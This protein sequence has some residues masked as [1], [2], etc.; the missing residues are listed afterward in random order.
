MIHCIFLAIFLPISSPCG[1]CLLMLVCAKVELNS[2]FSEVMKTLEISNTRGL[3][4]VDLRVALR[5]IALVQDKDYLTWTMP[6]LRK[7][8]GE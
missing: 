8:K 5:T 4:P 7:S 1:N 6:H 3:W 2:P